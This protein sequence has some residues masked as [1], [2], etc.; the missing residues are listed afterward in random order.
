MT[1]II[2]FKEVIKV[3]DKKDQTPGLERVKF[4]VAQE[5]GLN[6]TAKNKENEKEIKKS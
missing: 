6:K 4:E 1:G 2:I 5:M 3:E